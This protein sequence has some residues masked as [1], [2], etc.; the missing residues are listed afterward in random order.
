MSATTWTL[1]DV[2]R[3]VYVETLELTPD[4]APGAARGYRVS[5]RRLRGGPCDG[6]DLI[7]VDNGAFRFSVIPTRGMGLWRAALG[8]LPLGWKSPVRG[9]VHPGFVRLMTPNGLGWLDGF[10]ELLARC[11]LE[12]NGAPE[13]A[14]DG[15]LRY[16]LHG[17]IANLPAHKVAVSID[18]EAGRISV[19]GEVDEAR[20]FHGK[21]RL[22]TSYVTEIGRPGVTMVDTV[23]NLSAEP[24]E[25]ELLYHINFGPPLM[26]PE[27]RLTLPVAKVAPRDAVAAEDLPA[28][29]VYRPQTPGM[30]EACFYCRPIGDVNG[31]SLAVLHN[32]A[33]SQ[34]AAVRFNVHELPC[35]TQWKN[36]LAVADGYVTGLEPATNFPNTK[37]FEK[38]QGRVV[39]L[40]PGQLRSFGMELAALGDADA[41]AAACAE[42]ARLQQ[43]TTPEVWSSPDPEWAP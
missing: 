42:V 17:R 16:P 33:A 40:E 24:G 14:P 11:G 13:F 1:T 32:A 43:G 30:K 19:T 7:E 15:A 25:F 23:V 2:N 5:K 9:P 31:R 28:W 12:S 18:G 20:M 22:V 34:G 4:D 8:E 38:S 6:V 27:A 35:F 3:N 10:D 21:L 37:S 39:S 36:P 29:N 26:E 41:V